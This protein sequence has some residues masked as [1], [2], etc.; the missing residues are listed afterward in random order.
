MSAIPPTEQRHPASGQL[1]RMAPLAVIELMN[2]DEAKV[3]DALAT[4]EQQLADAAVQVAAR[5]SDQA[6]G[7]LIL[8]AA[9]TG[10]RVAQQ[11]CGE[12]P[13]S[14]GLPADR[15]LALVA[16]RRFLGDAPLAA[17]ED[18]IADVPAA[19]W[20]I[21][22]G[23][24]DAVIGLAASGTT[25]FVR[26]CVQQARQL[27][28]WTCGIANN[29][30]SPLLADADLG[31]CLDTGPEIVTGSTRLKAATAQKLALNR[32]T[33]AAMVRCGHVIGNEMVDMAVSNAKLRDRARRI[34][35]DLTG[36]TPAAATAALEATSWNIRAALVAVG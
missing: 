1:D 10:A 13:V 26:A 11:E 16:G 7:R 3:L 17:T 23:P 28:A 19:L 22:V 8:A 29:P 33:T 18:E 21:G 34:V 25:P 4:V 30:G 14:F 15:M 35:V 31:I 20:A 32:I 2:R 27:G 5:L 24:A 6:G 36:C 12:V 9:G